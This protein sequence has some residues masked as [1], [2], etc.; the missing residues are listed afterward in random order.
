MMRRAPRSLLLALAAACGRAEPPPPPATELPP[1]ATGYDV[2]ATEL[3]AIPAGTYRTLFPGKDDPPDLSVAPFLLEAHPVTNEQFRA[4]VALHPQWRRSLVPR[5]FA[6]ARYLRQWAGDL[7]LAPGT[8][9]APVTN[10]SWFAA[11]AYAR[12]RGRRLPTLAEWERVAAVGLFGP[13]GNDE[14]EWRQRIL[15][16]YAR[17]TPTR[18]PPVRSTPRNWLGVYDVHGLV[19]EWVDDFNT[20]LVTGE[21]RGDRALERG[22]YCGSGSVAAADP[23]DYAAFMRFAFRS[24]LQGSYAIGT[25]GFRCAA[26][27]DRR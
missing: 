24:T 4:F 19:W 9:T 18:H 26:E 10:V 27:E 12:W 14:P 20:A 23:G 13:S 17:P 6:D 16:W 8:E 7:E 11:R 2:A 5:V 25:L 21:S 15:D 22:L 1:P 3:I